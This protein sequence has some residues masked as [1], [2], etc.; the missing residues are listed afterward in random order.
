VVVGVTNEAEGLVKKWI[1][2]K[3][4]AYPVVIVAGNQT[5][6]AYGIKGFP[7][8]FLVSAEGNVAWEGHPSSLSEGELEKQLEAA[9][10]IPKL[11]AQ[12][13]PINAELEKKQYGKAHALIEK[14]LAKGESEPLSKTKA[15]IE[16]VAKRNVEDADKKAAAG[17]YPAAAAGLEEVSKNWKGLPEADEAAKKLKDWKADKSIKGQLAAAD[18]MKK[19]EALEK[20]GD[21]GKKK[22]YGIYVEVAKKQKGTKI[23]EK[24]QAAAERIKGS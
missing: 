3:K 17:D 18:E 12:Y 14:E 1:D 24:A 21:A 9:V 19:A 16:A 6:Q 10:F 15:A 23:G 11:P 8:S 7:H 13:G 4:A 20:L 22:A 5:D 2:E